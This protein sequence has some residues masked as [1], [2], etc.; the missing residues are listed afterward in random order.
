[1][2][3][4]LR[5]ATTAITSLLN[6]TLQSYFK[7]F[8]TKISD[9]DNQ[10]AALT[11]MQTELL[12]LKRE[13]M[14]RKAVALLSGGLDSSLAAKMMLDMGI[15]VFGINFIM[16]FG[17]PDSG[18]ESKKSEALKSAENL[19]ISLNTVY[20]GTDYMEMVRK[21]SHGYGKAINPCVD[22]HIFFI[23]KAGEYMRQI[24][25]DFLVTGEVLGQ[26]PMSQRRDSMI[27]IERESGLS[28]LILR[29]LSAHHFDPTIPE[30]EGWVDRSRLLAIKGRSRQEQFKLA[31]QTGVKDYPT[32]AGGCH[33]TELTFVAKVKDV[34]TH[35]DKLELRDFQLLK[36][37]R[38]FRIGDRTKAI[39]GRDENDNN[40]LEQTVKP[41]ESCFFWLDGKSP[42][43]VIV[44]EQLPE[45]I[46]LASRLLLRYTKAA[47]GS[48]C[49]I[50]VRI[51]GTETVL[52]AF[53]NITA[54]TMQ[55]LRID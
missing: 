39:I 35:S 51:N 23:K 12:I 7:L 42:I 48:E 54:E 32:P 25:A 5:I 6:Q 36:T 40:R 49:R 33:L 9:D 4:S 52:H 20:L 11:L 55:Q 46:A 22:C 18:P 43:G 47:P 3:R 14:K 28:G 1:M 34:F 45:H 17:F 13:Y 8:S 10:P 21:P 29:P 50:G 27:L 37:G 38:H 41:D 30:L 2:V 26:R 16:P 15:E 53:N 31:E 24:G 44:G 19:G